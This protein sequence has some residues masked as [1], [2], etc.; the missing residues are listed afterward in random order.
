MVNREGFV[1]YGDI[2]YYCKDGKVDE[3]CKD[4]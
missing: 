2:L 3:M 4:V 1:C